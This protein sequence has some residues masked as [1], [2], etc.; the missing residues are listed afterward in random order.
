MF[1]KE[2]WCLKNQFKKVCI[3]W[4]GHKILWNIHRRFALCSNGQIYGGDFAKFCGL[5][6]IYELYKLQIMKQLQNNY[7]YLFPW[8]Q[9][10]VLDIQYNKIIIQFCP[11]KFFLVKF[12]IPWE[13]KLAAQNLISLRPVDYFLKPIEFWN[14]QCFA[15]NT[16]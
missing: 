5:L 8:W 6:R 2:K 16:N 4:E 15:I 3:F 1:E 14:Q 11:G 13:L 7:N 9:Q 12:V 10:R